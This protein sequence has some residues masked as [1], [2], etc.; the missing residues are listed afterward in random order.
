MTRPS[1]PLDPR[2]D[3]ELREEI[4][5]W[6]RANGVDP[7]DIPMDVRMTLGERWVSTDVFVRG[8]GG[9]ILLTAACDD[10]QLET[11]RFVVNVPPAGRV[12]EWLRR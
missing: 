3:N 11:R 8:P 6:L 1:E 2:H 10:V 7:A 4:C 9:G 5:A 12:L